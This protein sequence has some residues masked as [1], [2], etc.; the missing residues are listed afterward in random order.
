MFHHG[1]QPSILCPIFP[2]RLCRSIVG[3]PITFIFAK[4]NH[5]VNF[6][7]SIILY[8]YQI[9]SEAK[10][11]ICAKFRKKPFSAPNSSLYHLY[12]CQLFQVGI[13]IYG[14][15]FQCQ[16]RRESRPGSGG[17]RGAYSHSNGCWCEICRP[18]VCVCV[19]L[20]PRPGWFLVHSTL[21]LA[22]RW[23]CSFSLQY[24]N[25]SFVFAKE[26]HLVFFSKKY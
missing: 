5:H 2:W 6:A 19:V 11:D 1:T 15:G 26:Q 24:S 20:W 16:P 22:L 3:L 13:L 9:F 23:D 17:G 8:L 21:R 12:M 18:P 4:I 25:W 7:E 10:I 14:G